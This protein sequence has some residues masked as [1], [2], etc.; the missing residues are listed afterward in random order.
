MGVIDELGLRFLGMV[1]VETRKECVETEL[2][3]K[4]EWV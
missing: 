3:W 4:K 2:S 1:S